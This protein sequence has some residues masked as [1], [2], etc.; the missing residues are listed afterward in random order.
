MPRWAMSTKSCNFGTLVKIDVS[1]IPGVPYSDQRNV[2]IPCYQERIKRRLSMQH[3]AVA[4]DVCMLNSIV[5]NPRLEQL[6]GL[7]VVA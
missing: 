2:V 5:A 4:S 7:S 1:S 3:H 6:F